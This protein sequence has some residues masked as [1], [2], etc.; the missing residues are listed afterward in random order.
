MINFTAQDGYDLAHTICKGFETDAVVL[1]GKP[2]TLRDAWTDMHNPKN[3]TFMYFENR[4]EGLMAYKAFAEIHPFTRYLNDEHCY[5]IEGDNK[6]HW[7]LDWIVAVPINME[8]V[9]QRYREA[10]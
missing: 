8:T 4:L 5:T 10:A 2:L 9:T 1:N 3:W 7:E 6:E